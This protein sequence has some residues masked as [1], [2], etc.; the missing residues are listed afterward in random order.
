MQQS[1]KKKLVDGLAVIA[2]ARRSL[3]L[4]RREAFDESWRAR[5]ASGVRLP[6]E[7]VHDLRVINEALDLA[8]G[9]GKP[10]VPRGGITLPGEVCTNCGG[11]HGET[12][13]VPDLDYA[14]AEFMKRI[15]EEMRNARAG[16][17]S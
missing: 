10:L 16:G 8:Y 1:I 12:G 6:V 17:A 11:T 3:G 9:E 5:N 2:K 15:T 14:R 4:T 7:Q 13:P